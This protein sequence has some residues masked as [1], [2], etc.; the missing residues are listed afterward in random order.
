[1]CF[2]KQSPFVPEWRAGDQIAFLTERNGYLPTDFIDVQPPAFSYSAVSAIKVTTYVNLEFEMEFLLEA[3]RAITAPIDDLTNNVVNMFDI[4]LSD[5]N[6]VE[7]VPEN[8]D[9]DLES[10]GSIEA[11]ISFAPLNENPESI[12]TLVGLFSAKFVELITYM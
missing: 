7:S 10:D 9:I 1:M 4:S 8:I 11:D 2:L 12:L 5:I 3:V 6:L